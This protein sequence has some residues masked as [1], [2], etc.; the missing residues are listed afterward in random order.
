MGAR[1]KPFHFPGLFQAAKAVDA[2]HLHGLQIKAHSDEIQVHP[3]NFSG[4][5]VDNASD[6]P[7]RSS[8]ESLSD[9][10][11]TIHRFSK[12]QTI[13]SILEIVLASTLSIIVENLAV[14][15]MWGGDWYDFY[16]VEKENETED[17]SEIV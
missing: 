8:L 4:C 15:F 12:V 5:L 9:E 14:I 7:E 2:R 3:L 6:D 13:F 1:E 11:F 16:I 17:L 10:C